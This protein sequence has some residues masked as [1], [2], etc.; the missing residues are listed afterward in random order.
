MFP[1]DVEIKGIL[2]L[3]HLFPFVLIHLFFT[4]NCTAKNPELCSENNGGCSQICEQRSKYCIFGKCYFNCHIDFLCTRWVECKCQSGYKLLANGK[5]CAGK[6]NYFARIY[7]HLFRDCLFKLA[8][9]APFCCLIV[10]K[11]NLD[12]L[13]FSVNISLSCVRFSRLI[14]MNTYEIKNEIKSLNN[15]FFQSL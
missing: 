2:L 13:K 15:P 5:N 1:L 14:R 6:L 4:I 11:F 8:T 3:I 10:S 7:W 9:I 12:L